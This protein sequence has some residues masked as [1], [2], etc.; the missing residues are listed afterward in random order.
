MSACAFADIV[1]VISSDLYPQDYF[2][3]AVDMVQDWA[4]VGAPYVNKAVRDIQSF[5]TYGMW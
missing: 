2:G 3:G 1:Q 5:T 4:I